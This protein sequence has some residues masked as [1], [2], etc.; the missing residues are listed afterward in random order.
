MFDIILCIH[1]FIQN[2]QIAITVVANAHYHHHY[3]NGSISI[4]HA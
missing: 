2:D 3:R 1:V 4:D